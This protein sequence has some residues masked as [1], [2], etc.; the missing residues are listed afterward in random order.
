V[1]YWLLA[2][3]IVSIF[4]AEPCRIQHNENFS[5][6]GLAYR[7]ASLACDQPGNFALLLV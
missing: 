5:Q 3:E 2:Q 4:N 7:L 6:Q 1:R